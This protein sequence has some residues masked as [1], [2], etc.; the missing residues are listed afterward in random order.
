[1]N[2]LASF[3]RPQAWR[4]RLVLAGWT[5]GAA[6]ICLRAGQIQVVQG[7][8]WSALAEAQHTTDKEVVAARG[9]V[10]DRDGALLA[11]SRETYRVSIAPNELGDPAEVATLL[12]ETLDLSPRKAKQLVSPE[13]RWTVVPGRFP[14]GIRERLSGVRGVYVDRELD[15]YHPHG[16]LARGALGVVMDGV[17]QGGIEQTYD[18]V[19]RGRSGREVVA[20]DNVGQPIPGETFLVEAPRSGGQ[21]VLTLDLDLQ[22]IARQALDEAIETS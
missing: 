5:T 9:S 4:R 8:Q 3:M 11:V 15:R 20:R 7:A 14:P 16:D 18:E 1:M 6:I 12:Q 13:R 10:M 2:R 19:L 21:V 17:G 22:E